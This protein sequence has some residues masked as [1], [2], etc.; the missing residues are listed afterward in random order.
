MTNR[1]LK[2]IP[3]YRLSDREIMF[4]IGI[5]HIELQK[6]KTELATIGIYFINGF[7]I[8]KNEYK[9]FSWKG[10]K[11]DEAKDKLWNEIPDNVIDSMNSDTLSIDYEYST[12]RVNNNNNKSNSKNN[13]KNN[14]IPFKV[15][16]T[17]KPVEE[18]NKSNPDIN[19]LINY[20]KDKVGHLDDVNKWNRIYAKH[21][22]TRIKKE[23]PDKDPV[24]TAKALIDIGLADS[25]HSKNMTS[26]K[27]IY[28]NQQKILRS[29][30]ANKQGGN[31]GK[32]INI[33]K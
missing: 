13:S 20:L 23:Y 27:Y 2:L 29:Y 4:D 17:L 21:L 31:Q 10:K 26:F 18:K 9:P 33:I 25:F 24:A 6:L 8:L 14:D 28:G 1:N 32:T 7:C 11:L 30:Q 12:D 16:E 19:E 5:E 15:N 3:V 22:L